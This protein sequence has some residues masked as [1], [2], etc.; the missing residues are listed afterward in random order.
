M[1]ARVATSGARAVAPFMIGGDLY[2]GVPQLAKDVPG[3]PAH[4][5]GGD[6]GPSMAMFCWCEGR[7]VAETPLPVH[8]GEDAEF[9]HIGERPFFA[10]ASIRQG[11]GSYD[12]DVASTIFEWNGTTF[13]PFWAVPTF[14]AKQWRHFK[15]GDC[16]FLALAQGVTMDGVTPKNPAQSMIMEWDGAN[17]RPFQIVASAWGYNWSHF[18]IAGHDFLAYAD[19]RAPSIL[20]RCDGAGF[21]TFQMLNGDSGRAFC[22]FEADGKR[23]LAFAALMGDTLLYRW[24]DERFVRHQ[25]LNGPGGREFASLSCGGESYLIQVNFLTG[26]PQAPETVLKSVICHMSEGWLV[27]A[28]TF[29]TSGATDVAAFT[30]GNETFVAVAESLS[31][32]VRFRTDSRIYAFRG[33]GAATRET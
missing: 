15:I 19:H 30:T 8:G 9:F 3:T 14:A 2:L 5:N 26:T 27:V 10:I 21:E 24:D 33:A 22:F 1:P 17:F 12:L 18:R 16:H 20:L 25:V 32:E 7:F 28:D 4:L 13:K 31:K 29:A 23:F 6:S 11:N